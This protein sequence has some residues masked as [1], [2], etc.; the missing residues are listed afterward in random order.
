M[1]QT[2]PATPECG[3]RRLAINI[4]LRAILDVQRKGPYY[5]GDKP[6]RV[7]AN[8]LEW[9][10]AKDGLCHAL[11]DLLHADHWMLR[12]RAN[13]INDQYLANRRAA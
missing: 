11:C 6:E 2:S 4:L 3:Y 13:D 1:Q 8:A 7:A 12:E 10:N 5:K 9:I